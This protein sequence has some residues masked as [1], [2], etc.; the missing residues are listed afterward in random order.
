MAHY[1]P[2]KQGKASQLFDVIVLV[3][4]G[5]AGLRPGD[6]ELAREL[7]TSPVPVI[8][9]V[10]KAARPD[11]PWGVNEIPAPGLGAPLPALFP[12]GIGASLYLAFQIPQKQPLFPVWQGDLTGLLETDP[13]PQT[14]LTAH[15]RPITLTDQRQGLQQG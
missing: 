3:V 13:G 7:R 4:D 1:Q 6:D 10:N 12:E 11:H 14:F 15:L 9:A 8:V 2:P 5:Q